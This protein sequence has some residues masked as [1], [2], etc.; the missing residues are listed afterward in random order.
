MS[1]QVILQRSYVHSANLDII[2]G[3]IASRNKYRLLSALQGKAPPFARSLE[4]EDTVVSTLSASA[5]DDDNRLQPRPGTTI[6]EHVHLSLLAVSVANAPSLGIAVPVAS[7][8]CGSSSINA[9]RWLKLLVLAKLL[10]GVRDRRGVDHMGYVSS[11]CRPV[12][13]TLSS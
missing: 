2:I 11:R 8:S 7:T 13:V 4:N 9:L 3:N 10:R 6:T 5:A 1:H 12:A